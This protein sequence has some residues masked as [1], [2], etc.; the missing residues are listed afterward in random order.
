MDSLRRMFQAIHT[1]LIDALKLQNLREGRVKGNNVLA[2]AAIVVFAPLLAFFSTKINAQQ[3][4]SSGDKV[5]LNIVQDEIFSGE[6][7][8]SDDGY[9]HL[10]YLK[11]LYVNGLT[12]EDARFRLNNAFTKNKIFTPSQNIFSLR[13]T[14]TGSIVVSVS[15]E[16]F[17]S[18][19]FI[20]KKYDKTPGYNKVIPRNRNLFNA[21]QMA[22][23]VTPYADLTQIIISRNRKI[24]TENI[25]ELMN[26]YLP[27]NIELVDG[28]HIHVES[29]KLFNENLV[30]PSLIT[31]DSIKVFMA[32]NN[33]PYSGE[34]KIPYG[35]RVSQVL[36]VTGCVDKNQLLSKTRKIMIV[37][38]YPKTM[39]R[40]IFI[41]NI[42]EILF[43]KD[44]EKNTLL[45]PYD[46]V[47][48]DNSIIDKISSGLINLSTIVGEK[49]PFYEYYLRRDE[50][51]VGQ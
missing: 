39:K 41:N 42:G 49:W 16:V 19:S 1:G 51:S 30:K 12:I 3:L 5:T 21:L 32:T 17:N 29:S 37:R 7:T 34:T 27:R 48:C 2:A 33:S 35:S 4:L 43:N 45:Q 25:S 10:P 31:P 50:R 22:D 36:S 6:Y 23:G 28:D 44:K 46:V 15:G 11:R 14:E 8:I 20:L 9:L 13:R 26:G 47:V 40:E 38:D 18:G 24:I